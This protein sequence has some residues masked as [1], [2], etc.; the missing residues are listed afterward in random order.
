MNEVGYETV[1]YG[2]SVTSTHV[3]YYH[4]V[5]FPN[6]PLSRCATIQRCMDILTR[7]EIETPALRAVLPFVRRGRKLFMEMNIRVY[8]SKAR[9]G[10][11]E[12]RVSGEH[13]ALDN[14][15]VWFTSDFVDVDGERVLLLPSVLIY[16]YR[17]K[18]AGVF[19]QIA[20]S[21]SEGRLI[22]RDRHRVYPSSVLSC[23]YMA[24]VCKPAL[25]TTLCGCDG[26]LADHS[27]LNVVLCSLPSEIRRGDETHRVLRDQNIRPVT[28]NIRAYLQQPVHI[29]AGAC[30]NPSKESEVFDLIYERVM[31]S[32]D[33]RAVEL[34]RVY[35]KT[36]PR[37]YSCC[38][39]IHPRANAR[40]IASTESG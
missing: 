16:D 8:K 21:G 27:I 40:G 12:M 33:R 7:V 22:L 14:E 30:I 19:E 11:L 4:V 31:A 3:R 35:Q 10:K 2:F 38:N 34:R 15:Q 36:H 20:Y 1:D 5:A 18:A 29:E 23:V 9:E 32:M 39:Q 25:F 24:A 28:Y 13:Q 6:P 17:E 37:W 26:M